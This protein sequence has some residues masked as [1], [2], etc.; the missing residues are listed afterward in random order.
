MNTLRK[1]AAYV[2]SKVHLPLFPT[3]FEIRDAYEVYSE[4][5]NSRQRNTAFITWSRN[6]AIKE[7]K[8]RNS[9]KPYTVPRMHWVALR[10]IYIDGQWHKFN[11]NPVTIKDDQ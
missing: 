11:S 2:S 9:V 1:I 4:V 6:K 5:N 7:V 10:V 3:P 8:D